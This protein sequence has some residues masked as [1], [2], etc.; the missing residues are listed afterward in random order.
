MAQSADSS[1]KWTLAEKALAVISALLAVATAYLGLQTAKVAQAKQQA[2]AAVVT[3][4]TDLIAS[5][6]I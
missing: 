2:Q 5:E 6:S 1:R 4:D 3:K